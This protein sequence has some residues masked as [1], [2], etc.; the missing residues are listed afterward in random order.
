MEG[1]DRSVEGDAEGRPGASWDSA[2]ELTA[3]PVGTEGGSAGRRLDHDAAIASAFELH[4][5]E[6]YSFLR[7]SVRDEDAAED[8]LQDAF[9]RL[10]AELRAGRQPTNTRAWLYRVASNL[11]IDRGRRR[12]SVVRFLARQ[13]RD[14]G[15]SQTSDSPESDFVRQERR[16]DLERAL[17]MLP[18]ESRAA[19][20][21][22]S[23]G[24]SGIEIAE[25]IGRSHAATRTLLVRARRRVRAALEAQ[26][27]RS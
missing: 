25:A 15:A 21:L 26:E 16:Q 6:I 2:A 8:L 22:S 7:R 5:T 4:Q 23:E 27:A 11:V 12:A 9:M 13:P 24:F 1:T 10:F 17:A 18:T 14:L 19:L 20:L 3:L